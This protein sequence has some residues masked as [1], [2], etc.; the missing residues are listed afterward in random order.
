MKTEQK[1]GLRKLSLNRETLAPLQSEKLEDVNGGT[2]ISVTV[3]A[4]VTLTY[5]WSWSWDY[6]TK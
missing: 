1:Q 3:S 5:S 2:S 4:S 6:R